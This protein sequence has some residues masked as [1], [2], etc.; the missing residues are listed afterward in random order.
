MLTVHLYCV[1]H[2]RSALAKHVDLAKK[3][4]VLYNIYTHFTMEAS[5]LSTTQHFVDEHSKQ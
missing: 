4:P 3:V 5:P 2:T 1:Q